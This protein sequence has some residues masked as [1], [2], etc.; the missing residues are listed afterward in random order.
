MKLTKSLTSFLFMAGLGLTAGLASA[1]DALD[2]HD[3]WSRAT[4]AGLQNGVAY[5]SISNNGDKDDVLIGA[6]SPV[7]GK[8]ELHTHEKDGDVLRMRQLHEVPLVAG[9][10]VAFEPRGYHVMLMGLHEPL[11]EGTQF[12]LTLE[13]RSADDITVEVDV[14]PLGR[15]S[16]S[17]HHH[18]DH[19]HHHHDH[20]HH[21]N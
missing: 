5:F 6:R 21:H 13:F 11:K 20:H 2:V 1:Q 10:T 7:S 4:V 18:H 3:A 15:T 9:E 14:K 19:D 8:A 16:P 12:P 17:H